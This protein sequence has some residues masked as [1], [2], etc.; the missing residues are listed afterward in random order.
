MSPREIDVWSGSP[1]QITNFKAYAVCV[2]MAL[3]GVG[4]FVGVPYAFWRYL[5]VKNQRFEITTQ[6]I[7][8]RK[9]VLSKHID[10]L[11]LYRV[12]DTRFDQPFFLRIFGLGNIIVISSDSTDPILKINAIKDSKNIREK[13][14]DLV[15]D[16]RYQKRVRFSEFD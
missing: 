8:F 10:E 7:R 3:T 5:V 4:I 9:G 15:E 6:R 1:S 11:E 16:Q 14:R 13:L 2:L 12:K